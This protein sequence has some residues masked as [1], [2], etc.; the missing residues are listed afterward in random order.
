MVGNPT[1]IAATITI[2]T[3]ADHRGDRWVKTAPL[4]FRSVTEGVPHVM[5]PLFR[6]HGARPTYLLTTEVMND[7]ESVETLARATDCELGTHLHGE[8]VAP[9]AR[10][11]DPAGQTSWDFT[12]C[13]P[14]EI[15]RGKLMTITDQFRDRFG[16]A[17]LSYRAGRY[18]ASGRT[19][20]Y[21][22]ELGYRA[23]TSVTPRIEW[24]NEIDAT[25]RMDFRD[26]PLAPYHPAE[27]DLAREGGLP[28]WEFPVTILERPA[29]WN[30]ALNVAQV[31]LRRPRQS[32]PVWLRPS[33]TSR[34]WLW[35]M[36]HTIMK[37]P[38]VKLFNIMFHSMEV[39]ADASPYN[40]NGAATARIL[41]RLD[42]LLAMLKDVGARFYTTAEL[43]ETLG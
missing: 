17:P 38:G 5:A 25:H 20:R 37:R 6:K 29:I 18:G 13:Y 19:A 22:A 30:S 24:I 7:A 14:P 35:W 33:T 2:D 41:S 40:P 23:E 28:I 9:D 3:E 27:S 12:C 42:F 8:H 36:V 32:Y 10:L 1:M 31:A 26:A 4:T 39:I 34:A 21:L 43:A 15:E 11:P 16:R